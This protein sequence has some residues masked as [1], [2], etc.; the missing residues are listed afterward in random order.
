MS[1]LP[2]YKGYQA[3]VEYSVED[4]LVIGEV[5][6][7]RDSLN[8]HAD[9][10]DPKEIEAIFHQCIDD[11][12]AFCAELGVDPDKSYSG[13]FNVRIGAER[14]RLAEQEAVRRGVSLNQFVSDAIEHEIEGPPT[15]TVYICLPYA[16]PMK[17]TVCVDTDKVID[18]VSA[19][20]TSKKE[21]EEK[22]WRI[23]NG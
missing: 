9:T 13:S 3:K 8:F 10:V 7:V 14:H 4:G 19:K 6:G 5:I 20:E 17:S 16:A 18:F 21:G 2:S 23:Q 15:E 1:V 11:Y 22:Q 12:L